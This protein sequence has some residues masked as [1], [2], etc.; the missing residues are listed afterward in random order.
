[1]PSLL[2]PSYQ[3]FY[4]ALQNL[5]RF[6]KENNFFDNI[7]SLDSFLSEYRSTTLVMQKSLGD[8][9]Y[10][11]VYK[12]ISK[13][14]WDPFFNDQRVKTVHLHPIEILKQITITVYLPGINFDIQTKTFSVED[15][16]PLASLIDSLKVFFCNINNTEVFFSADFTFVEKDSEADLWEKLIEGIGTMQKFMDDM[17]TRIGEKCPLC[18]ELRKKS[19]EFGLT[20]LPRDFFLVNDYVYYPEK[21]EFE[22][23]GRLA[24]TFP[25]INVKE[26]HRIPLSS[27]MNAFSV[28]ADI[29]TFDKFMLINCVIGSSDLMP[30]LMTVYNDETFE[31]DIFH[32]DIK[33]TIYRK[34][35]EIA[36]K[37]ATEDVNEVYFMGT[38]VFVDYK[39]ELLKLS[40]K[41]RIARA[42]GEHLVFMKVDSNLNETECAFEEEHIHEM[43]YVFKQ[44]QCGKKNQLDIGKLNMTPIITAFK[45]RKN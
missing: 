12:E 15:D 31:M 35:N 38:Y 4:S 11:D 25:G 32:T 26:T 22:R 6:D 5:K 19:D 29:S 42:Q 8:T 10:K 24:I 13:G 30:T 1:M 43:A 17:Y 34:I 20:L 16:I 18:E 14:I 41:E 45:N 21:D 2:Y 23:A 28:G 36:K 37:I 9:Q 39:D 40:S 7:S 33:T 3:K 44:M 27:F